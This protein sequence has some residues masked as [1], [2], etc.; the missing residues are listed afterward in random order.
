V[1]KELGCYCTN[2]CWRSDVSFD[3]RS[4]E[5]RKPDLDIVVT[6]K[7]TYP[8]GGDCTYRISFIAKPSMRNAG[9]LASE[10]LIDLALGASTISRLR[11]CPVR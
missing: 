11:G 7:R 10:F 9:N 8:R 4:S 6:R 5:K 3:F 2:I 1:E